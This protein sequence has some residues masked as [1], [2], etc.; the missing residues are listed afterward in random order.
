MRYLCSEVSERTSFDPFAS[1]HSDL[2]ALFQLEKHQQ[3]VEP[4]L[5]SHPHYGDKHRDRLRRST[6]PKRRP[7]QMFQQS[8]T[9]DIGTITIKRI[10]K[11]I[12]QGFFLTFWNVTSC[13]HV[14][15]F[16]ICHQ[17]GFN[18]LWQLNRLNCWHVFC[19]HCTYTSCFT[20]NPQKT[21]TSQVLWFL[22]FAYE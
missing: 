21:S 14:Q 6:R 17:R 8:T 13:D 3:Y 16:T 10:F 15:A 9:G 19:L 11:L 22:F 5:R 20:K 18:S 4:L 2:D 7:S 12:I 1:P